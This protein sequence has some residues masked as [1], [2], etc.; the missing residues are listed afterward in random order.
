VGKTSGLG[1]RYFYGGYDLSGDTN[2][3]SK[4]SGPQAVQDVTD[5]TQSAHAR[6]GLLRDG[7]IDWI[8]YF[9]PTGAHVI[10]STLPRADEIAT[11]FRGTTL[12]NPCASCNGKQ[13]NYDQ[14]RA[15]TGELTG[16]VSMQANGFGLEW[17]EMLTPGLRTDT[18]ATSGPTQDDGSN[19]AGSGASFP[20]GVPSPNGAQGY[21]QVTAFNG[22][23]V[24]LFIE[25][26]ANGSAWSTLIDFGT[27]SGIGDLRGVALGTVNRYVRASSGAGT[28]VS[29]TFAVQ[30]V[31]NAVAT[32]F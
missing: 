27:I 28:F 29:V 25:H 1:D 13:L 18:A 11:Y 7:A 3:L 5:I 26:S 30:F 15:A 32:S 20:P 24:D 31:R 9:D 19:Y 2:S 16:A 22:T 6:L 8:T 17:G 4:I 10:L 23:G 14:T 21:L 12:G